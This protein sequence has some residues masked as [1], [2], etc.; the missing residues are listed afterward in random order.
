M[1][2][3]E[4]APATEGLVL[5]PSLSR[6]LAACR[7]KLKFLQTNISSLDNIQRKR[8]R[9]RQD[10]KFQNQ[11]GFKAAQIRKVQLCIMHESVH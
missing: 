11:V 7:A 4:F 9:K 6:T 3:I 2:S 10:W 5:K 8:G 1:P